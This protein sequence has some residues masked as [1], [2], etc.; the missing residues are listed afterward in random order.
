MRVVL[1]GD[2]VLVASG[3]P[4][5]SGRVTPDDKL[6]FQNIDHSIGWPKAR[7]VE[8]NPLQVI[9]ALAEGVRNTGIRRITG[10]VPGGYTSL[11]GRLS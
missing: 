10:T 5:L 7:L 11:P 4:N 3:D 2:L 8:R 6:D 9:E 1:Q